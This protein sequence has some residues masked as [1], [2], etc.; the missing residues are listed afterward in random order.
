MGERILSAFA[1][2]PPPVLTFT[3]EITLEAIETLRGK[4]QLSSPDVIAAVGGGKALDAGKA[5]ARLLD[6]PV[7]SVPTIASMDG[8][9][10]RGIAIYDD[11][12]RLALVQ[13]LRS[14]PAVVLVDT[15]VIAAAPVDF[16]RAGIGDAIAKK[17]EA[18]G[19]AAAGA[20]NK[21]GTLPLR[22]ARLAAD[23]AYRLLRAHSAAAVRAVARGVLNDDVEATIE[24]TILL[25]ALGYENAGL[26]VAHSFSRGLVK[27]RGAEKRPHGFH[28]AYGLLVQFAV[29]DRPDEELADIRQFHKD[30][31][32]PVRLADL[33][34]AN[35]ARSE[36]GAMCEL[37]LAAPHINNIATTI[38]LDGLVAAVDRVERQSR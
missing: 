28:I 17:F 29:E 31:G 34:L 11:E 24:A 16:L 19:A 20:L 5:V 33:G 23:G 2:S 8:P 35:A 27:A 32:L 3:G 38:D 15:A 1:G 9:A 36:I 26:S 7:I 30:V 6:L 10:S 21:H 22:S 37:A 4:A 25:S 12:H 14:N 13:Q 18:E